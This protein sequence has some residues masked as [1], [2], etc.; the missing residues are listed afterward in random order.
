MLGWVKI[1]YAGQ[2]LSSFTNLTCFSLNGHLT[3][4]IPWIRDGVVAIT[5]FTLAVILGSRAIRNRVYEFF[6]ATHI[7]LIL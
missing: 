6:L 1:G 7:I 3:L 2:R 4:A 5:A